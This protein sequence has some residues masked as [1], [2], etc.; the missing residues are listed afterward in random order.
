MRCKLQSPVC[1][2]RPWR[3]NSR[4]NL[5]LDD[6][7]ARW[8]VESWEVALGIEITQPKAAPITAVTKIKATGRT[9]PI[10]PTP[11]LIPPTPGVGV[12][13][14]AIAL[15]HREKARHDQVKAE[16]ERVKAARAEALAVQMQKEARA[17][18]IPVHK[19]AKRLAEQTRDFAAAARMLEELSRNGAM[20]S[21]TKTFA[22]IATK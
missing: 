15:Q 4:G 2:L 3:Q 14:A 9:S 12:D 22:V 16:L 10:L 17:H 5:G 20:R 13:L 1:S 21:C 18:A 8:S 19:E 6:G 11:T 7:V